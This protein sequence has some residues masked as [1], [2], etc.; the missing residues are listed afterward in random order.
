MHNNM[1][2]EENLKGSGFVC[3]SI[4]SLFY[5]SEETSNHLFFDC[6]FA[7]RFWSWFNSAISVPIDT[8]SLQS[9]LSTCKKSWSPQ[10]EVVLLASII[11]ILETIW[12]CR[13]QIKFDSKVVS[14]R[15]AVSMV[16]GFT[17]LSGNTFAGHMSSSIEEFSILKSFPIKCH[18]R[19]A[20]SIIQVDWIPLPCGWIK[21]NTDRAAKGS[22]G[23]AAGDIPFMLSLLLR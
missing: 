23:H 2:M 9:V 13:N 6:D 12:F 3:V 5:K 15:S 22:P 14:F 10:R 1:P 11:N 16:I 4:C 17:S 20:P 8:S 7:R 18:P 21:A 19:K